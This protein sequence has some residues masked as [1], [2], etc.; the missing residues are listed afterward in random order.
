MKTVIYFSHDCQT[1]GDNK[2]Q[3]L[4]FR[5]GMQGY[6]VFWAIVENLY[7]NANAMP[8]H[9]NRIA[10]DLRVDEKLVQSVIEDF[11]LF[12]IQEQIISSNSVEKRLQELKIRSKKAKEKADKRWGNATEMPQHSQ[13]N[14]I[15]EKKRKEKK[16]NNTPISINRNKSIDRPTI[17]EV[18]D[19]FKEN[20][21]D[22]KKGEKAWKYYAETDWKDSKGNTVKN[23]KQK[24]QGVWF[25][26]ENKVV[27]SQP[28]KMVY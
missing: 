15:K 22:P 13:S 10:F 8:Q 14:A 26:D 25:K 27:N 9:Y 28:P 18:A 21:Y 11:D 20:G 4:I 12:Q 24:M 5:H 7:I 16:V 19:Y 17:N 6:G 3:E 1:R 2:I 23:W